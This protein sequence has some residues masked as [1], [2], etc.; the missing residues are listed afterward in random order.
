MRSIAREPIEI[1]LSKR[2]T[3]LTFLGAIAFVAAGIWMITTADTQERY[4]PT[5]LTVIGYSAVVFFGAAALF[6]FYKLFESR[7]GLILDSEG[8]HNNTYALSSQ[9][10][11]WDQIKR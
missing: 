6:S 8:I 5:R 1:K 7:P 4:S 10:I 9:L 2:K 3:I 11:R